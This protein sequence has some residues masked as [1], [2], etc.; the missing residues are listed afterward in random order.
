MN[1]LDH[2]HAFEQRNPRTFV[3]MYQFWVQKI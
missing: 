2:W 3:A 1:N